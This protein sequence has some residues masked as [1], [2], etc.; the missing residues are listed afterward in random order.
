MPSTTTEPKMQTLRCQHGDG[1]D[2]TRPA[3]RGKPPRFCPAH[4]GTTAPKAAPKPQVTT[5][6]D[7]A[8]KLAKAREAA[9]RAREERK[10]REER[11]AVQKA[12]E[13]LERINN[14][15]DE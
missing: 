14:T 8:D 5:A 10:A 12:R 7:D 2:W 6:N 9:A 1:H 13:E 15:I 4:K 3:Q 11:E